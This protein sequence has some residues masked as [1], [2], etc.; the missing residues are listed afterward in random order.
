MR[1]MN[2]DENMVN[3]FDVGTASMPSLNAFIADRAREESKSMFIN[4]IVDNLFYKHD[5]DQTE[6]KFGHVI[7]QCK[8]IMCLTDGLFG[9]IPKFDQESNEFMGYGIVDISALLPNLDQDLHR[10]GMYEFNSCSFFSIDGEITMFVSFVDNKSNPSKTHYIY[11]NGKTYDNL[12][13]FTEV[14]DVVADGL[15]VP[16]YKMFS[17]THQLRMFSNVEIALT[18]YGF[19]D[20]E[21]NT[22]SKKTYSY[23]GKKELKI[24][25]VAEFNGR[26][27]KIIHPINVQYENGDKV[28]EYGKIWKKFDD[29]HVGCYGEDGVLIEGSKKYLLEILNHP[30]VGGTDTFAVYDSIEDK[31]PQILVDMTQQQFNSQLFST[32]ALVNKIVQWLYKNTTFDNKCEHYLE[33]NHGSFI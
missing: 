20:I 32:P 3:P 17:K 23:R 21:P 25:D 4:D 27:D 5:I 16:T 24:T 28:V 26:D 1:K 6:G 22:T 29:T 9:L 31:P 11:M 33:Q 14:E 8:Y 10:E 7:P 13:G 30:F 2:P 19:W 15:I 18:D 12:Y